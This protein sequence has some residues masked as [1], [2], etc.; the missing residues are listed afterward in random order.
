MSSQECRWG[1]HRSGTRRHLGRLG[2]CKRL[3]VRQSRRCW[4]GSARGSPE[5]GSPR[6]RCRPARQFQLR[7]RLALKSPPARCGQIA[8][9]R[10]PDVSPK[11]RA[12]PGHKVRRGPGL[13]DRESRIGPAGKLPLRPT[14]RI[15]NRV[16]LPHAPRPNF[17]SPVAAKKLQKT[18]NYILPEVFNRDWESVQP[19]IHSPHRELSVFNQQRPRRLWRRGAPANA[20]GHAE[21][22]PRRREAH[23]SLHSRRFASA[24]RAFPVAHAASLPR[25]HRSHR[26]PLPCHL[27]GVFAC[28]R[29]VSLPCP[30]PNGQFGNSP[31]TEPKCK[32]RQFSFG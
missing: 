10:Q 32:N 2:S 17:P 11:G 8:P 3:A 22:L 28:L 7:R 4:R 30:K 15:C 25:Q 13:C 23:R 14:H 16:A 21:S 12:A 5:G 18:T 20:A 27:A 1:Q 31:G 26:Q 24:A 19:M 9:R 6:P 29:R